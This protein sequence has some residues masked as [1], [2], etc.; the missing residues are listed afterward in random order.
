MY[1][2]ILTFFAHEL[3]S[4]IDHDDSPGRPFV[5]LKGSD[6]VDA[7]KSFKGQMIRNLGYFYIIIKYFNPL[8]SKISAPS[9][10]S[11]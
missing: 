3:A 7:D 4:K 6:M 9:L 10:D 5:L 1:T 11:W 8:N 2:L